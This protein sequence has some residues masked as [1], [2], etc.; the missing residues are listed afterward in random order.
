MTGDT[1]AT[2]PDPR[3]VPEPPSYWEG[4]QACVRWSAV[5]RCARCDWTSDR[6]ADVSARNQA[7]EHATQSGHRLCGVCRRSLSD[8]DPEFACESCL[9]EAREFLAGIMLMHD[10]LATD[11]LGH[12]R[13]VVMDGGHGS[14]DGRPI[15]GGNVLVFLAGGSVGGAPRRLT[16]LETASPERWWLEGS[17]GPLTAAGAM[18]AERERMGREHAVDNWATDGMSVAWVLLSWEVDWRAARGDADV[19]ASRMVA[20]SPDAARGYL[21]VHARWAA[22]RLDTF[23]DFHA[24]L[25][26]LHATMG[27]ELGEVRQPTV[28]P[29]D[30]FACSGRLIHPVGEDG[31]EDP[32]IVCRG[33][34]Q[35]YTPD[36]YRM[37][38]RAALTEPMGETG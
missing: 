13:P 18:Q 1:Q 33:C 29:A 24:E 5:S 14:S 6:D 25:R 28:L 21:E 10:R 9:T 38:L 36:Q 3:V 19:P 34:G 8:T 23:P 11:G 17:C 30:C 7:A 26:D 20:A 31:L 35:E 37:A 15:P 22:N 16:T 32:G 2:K 4:D 12:L 27:R